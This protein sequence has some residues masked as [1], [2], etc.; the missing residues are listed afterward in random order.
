M[1]KIQISNKSGMIEEGHCTEHQ[2]NE[3]IQRARDVATATNKICT[4]T[5]QAKPIAFKVRPR[6]K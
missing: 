2:F 1:Y 5:F 3:W 6:K 4:V